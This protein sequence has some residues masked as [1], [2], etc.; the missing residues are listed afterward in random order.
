MITE[1]HTHD[2]FVFRKTT[3][4]G[5]VGSWEVYWN[6]W[7]AVGTYNKDET[8]DEIKSQWPATKQEIIS[9]RLEN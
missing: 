4:P 1:D 3:F 5:R 7:V 8:F 9:D 6:G 2:G